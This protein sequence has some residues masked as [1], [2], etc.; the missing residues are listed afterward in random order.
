MHNIKQPFFGFTSINY[1]FN[2]LISYPYKGLGEGPNCLPE[3]ILK[4]MARFVNFHI[5][6]K[7]N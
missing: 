7:Q 2:R 4:Q 1:H 3:L 5:G 6:Q